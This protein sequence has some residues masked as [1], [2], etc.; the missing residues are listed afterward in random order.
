MSLQCPV[1]PATCL[2]H[3]PHLASCYQIGLFSRAPWIGEGPGLET[4]VLLQFSFTNTGFPSCTESIGP[5]PSEVIKPLL[6]TSLSHSVTHYNATFNL[7]SIQ[8]LVPISCESKISS[9]VLTCQRQL[10][11]LARN[12][13]S[14][15]APLL[16]PTHKCSIWHQRWSSQCSHLKILSE[17]IKNEHFNNYLS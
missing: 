17:Q 6:P 2:S 14:Y 4:W 10:V 7:F 1:I 9:F 11:K 5:S 15:D 8:C 3:Q 16:R 13:T 12:S